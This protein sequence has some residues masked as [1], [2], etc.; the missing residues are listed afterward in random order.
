[1]PTLSLSK[2]KIRIVLLEGVHSVAV[3]TLQAAGYTS[4]ESLP[5]S[6]SG[7]Q[8]KKKI[9]GVHILGIRSRTQLTAEIFEAAEQLMAVG[10]FC[11]GTSQV[12]L[13]TATQRGVAV[14]N[15]PYSNTRSVAELVLAEAIM[16]ARR[17][18][19]KNSAAHHGVWLKSVDNA[20]EIRGK[21]LGIVGYGNIGSQLSVIAEALG[22]K[23]CFYDKEDKLPLGNAVAVD[24]LAELL[25]QADIVS[26]HVPD[27]ADTHSMIGSRELA[28]MKKG[29]L[30]INAARGRVIDIDALVQ[31]LHSGHVAGAAIDVFPQEPESVGQTFCSPLMGIDNVLLTPHIGGSTLE[32]QY[33]IGKD[34][35][36]R[37]IRYSDNGSTLMSVNLPSLA[38]PTHAGRHRIL[39]IHH[40]VPGM[41]S[42]INRI[43]SQVKINVTGQ[44]LQTRG[45]T[46]YVVTDIED[47]HDPQIVKQLQ[48]IEGTV[49][50]RILY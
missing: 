31:A 42:R 16:L 19:R 2:D 7:E 47:Q 5:S 25:G 18:P 32:A 8:L 43:Y 30:I 3:A 11:I 36:D 21:V 14:F 1:M 24:S 37:L 44:Y 23:V 49:H 17:I 33:H 27:S 20:F 15:A 50:C 46:G 26:L 39:H 40:N 29:G 28:W 9:Q 38:L 34:V 13:A 45:E 35:A 10:C 12:D 4:I 41:L 48:H 6:L 22:M